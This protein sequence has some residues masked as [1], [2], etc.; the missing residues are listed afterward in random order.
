[1]SIRP[2]ITQ[3]IFVAAAMVLIVGAGFLHQSLDKTSEDYELIAPGDV[4]AQEHPELAILTIA[5]GGLRS[6]LVNY[7]WIRANDLK[8]KGRY[9]DAMQL[10]SLICRLQPRF[11]GVWSFHSW[12]MAWNISV[13]THTPDE[14]WLWVSNGMELLRDEGIPLNPNS[15]QLYK[16]LG[17]IFFSKMG[18]Y[19]DDMNMVYKQRW[20]SQMQR[21]LAAP[22]YGDTEETIQAFRPIAQAPLDKDPRRQG[23][24][25]VQPDKLNEVLANEE[26]ALYAELLTKQG[27][28]VDESLLDAFNRFSTDDS[29][30]IVRPPLWKPPI[31]SDSDKAIAELINDSEYA[32]Q[33]NTLLAFVR[34]QILWNVYK[35]DPQWMLELMEKYGPLDWREVQP[36]GL[37][38]VTYGLH[39]TQELDLNDINTL[40]TDRIVV[41]SLKALTWNGRLTYVDNPEDPDA[42]IIA[43]TSDWRFI[44]TTQQEF[45]D[46]ID[47]LIKDRDQEFKDNTLKSGHINYLAAAIQML[48]AGGDRKDAQKYLDW[49]KE[50]YQ[51]KGPEWELDDLEDFVVSR[52]KSGGRPIPDLA[53]NQ[54]TAALISGFEYLALNRRDEYRS[55]MRYAKKVYDL[56]QSR[57]HAR[58]KL[59]P[60]EVVI[61]GVLRDILVRP[62]SRGLNLPLISRSRIYAAMPNSIQLFIYDPVAPYLARECKAQQIDFAK[63]FPS[64][65]G[66]E[67]FRKRQRRQMFIQ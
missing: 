20:A 1:M 64:P 29:I 22:P 2:G 46:I 10:A 6:V 25:A 45:L 34:A 4:V 58:N 52:L 8:E 39:K 56:Y 57:A 66:L 54:M 9:F 16:D 31:N 47:V 23:A 65:A 44:K 50:N 26:I 35:M 5:P 19:T 51:P 28:S 40:N 11:A 12:N 7:F 37:Y 21:L 36:H 53:R 60:F 67:E 38:W 18:Q 3:W 15:L 61:T 13:A 33:R 55:N 14:R 49:I 62:R 41:N 43:W 27:I 42:P 30:S 63:A 59:P 32:Q 24:Q 48:Y 17:W